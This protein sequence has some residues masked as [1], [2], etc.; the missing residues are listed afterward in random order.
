[1][2]K[3]FTFLGLMFALPFVASASS[4]IITPL[5]GSYTKGDTVTLHIS[6][7]P[8]GST[9]YTA[10]LNSQF[11]S[12]AFEVV[13]FTLN[14]SMLAMKQTGYD[15]INNVAGT[16]VKTGGYTGGINSVTPFGTLILRARGSGTGTFTINN[17]SK[18][19]DSNNTNKQVGSQVAS[20]KITDK[21]IAVAKKAEVQK[22]TDS[23]AKIVTPKVSETATT[24]DNSNVSD[25]Q[26]TSSQL[27]AV[28]QSGT[29]SSTLI[30][31]LGIIALI[32]VFTVGY[33]SGSRKWF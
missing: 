31:M 29:T 8:A 23:S 24:S 25:V 33:L 7:D 6:V 15:S 17:T 10:M 22:G 28:S 5:S 4:F 20:F 14:D 16:L 18:L 19:L 1:M 3:L 27:A 21:A 9:I 32:A 2:K 26:A 13:S 12:D 11:S 30:W